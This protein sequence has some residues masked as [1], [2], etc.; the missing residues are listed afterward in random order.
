MAKILQRSSGKM[1]SN[2]PERNGMRF[3]Q[4]RSDLCL[5]DSKVVK[6]YIV[7]T[8]PVGKSSGE[9]DQSSPFASKLV[10]VLRE[11]TRSWREI[12]C[13]VQQLL[14]SWESSSKWHRQKGS[15]RRWG[16]DWILLLHRQHLEAKLIPA[17]WAQFCVG[18]LPCSILQAKKEMRDCWREFQTRGA[19]F[20]QSADT[21]LVLMSCQA[22]WRE[23]PLSG[24]EFQTS[25]SFEVMSKEMLWIA[26]LI[27]TS[28]ATGVARAITQLSPSHRLKSLWFEGKCTEGNRDAR[29]PLGDRLS[30]Q[31]SMDLPFATD[32]LLPE[33]I[34]CANFLI[35]CQIQDLTLQ[36]KDSIL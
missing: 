10:T 24:W 23:R 18:V 9:E 7:S 34:W 22:S 3:N 27:A 11:R 6:N 1:F 4:I 12:D 20:D 31:M 32:Q 21:L 26:I 30:N 19:Q 16:V 29:Q 36:K 15:G 13:Q 5:R 8:F 2:L 14:L 33:W 35:F 28:A 17:D 25:W